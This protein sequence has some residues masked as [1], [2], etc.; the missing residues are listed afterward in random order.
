MLTAA[1]L[2]LAVTLPTVVSVAQVEVEEIVATCKPPNNGAGPLWCY[3]APLV[4]RQGDV[5]YVSAM[6]TGEGVPPLSNTR[7]R[8]FRR[9]E[10]GWKLVR[11]P[12]GFRHREPCPVVGLGDGRLGLSVNPSTEPPG[13]QYGRCD[14]HLLVFDARKLD[15]T[16]MALRPP[17]PKGVHFTDHSYRGIAADAARGEVLVLN[18]DA[19]TSAQHWAFGTAD[20]GFSRTGAIAFPIRACY[21]QV[22]L[23]DRAAHVMAIGDIVEPNETWRNFKKQKTGRAWDYVFRRLFYTSTP[24]ITK[25]DFAPPVEID[26]AEGT[27]GHISNLDLRVDP[28]GTAHLLYLKTDLTPTLRDAFFPGRPIVTTLEH[29]AIAGGKVS[30]RTTLA[31]GGDKAREPPHYAR[32]HVTGDSTLWVVELV[33]GRRTD[34]SSFVENRV[35]PI[36]PGGDAGAPI[37][38]ALKTPFTT[39]FTAS[40]RG[41]SRPADVLDLFGVGGDGETLRYARVRMTSP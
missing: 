17:W 15:E 28:D 30:R 23:R 27:A 35:F 22:A 7:W 4:V 2:W 14:P 12:E 31:T 6:E 19:T 36:R 9:D 16:P 1:I 24:D 40:E 3:G 39:F 29:V 13:T 37:L 10:R 11:Q 5:V 26:S 18:I 34:G 33:S 38:L 25:A 21:P 8:L 32:F 20:G 41:G